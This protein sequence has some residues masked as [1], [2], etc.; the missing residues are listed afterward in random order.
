MIK[1]IVLFLL[2]F[3]YCPVAVADF[4]DAVAACF[5]DPC[6]CGDS[7]STRWENWDGNRINKGKNNSVCP[8]WN[9]DGGRHDNTCL[10]KNPFPDA[11]IGYYENLC[12]E[13][14]P[15][16][17][18]SEP[19]IRVRGQQCNAFGC[20][21][22]SDTLSWDGECVTLVGGYVFPLHR[23]CARIAMP[24]DTERGFAQDPGYTYGKHLNFE[25]ATKDDDPI[26]TSDGETIILEAPKLCVYYDP[27]FFSFRDGDVRP[28][29]MDVDP[30]KQSY[31]KTTEVHP[32]AKVILFF[33][34]SSTESMPI[35]SLIT[36][37]A[38]MLDTGEEGETTFGSVLKDGFSFLGDILEWASNLIADFLEEMGQ[39]NRAVSSE[40]Y[41]CVNLPM[42]PFPP[43]YCESVAPFFQVAKTQ[44]ICHI[45]EDGLPVLSNERR[46]CVVSTLRNNYIRNSIRV[47]YENF[48]PLC[49]SGEDPMTTDKCVVIEGLDAFA[50]AEG[51]HSL[52]AR[53]DIIKPCSTAATG[54]LCVKTMIPHRCSVT[55]D[56]C[57]DGFRVVY[58]TEVGGVVSAQS[59][60]R[61][62]LKDCG[63]ISAG[64]TC[65]KIWGINTGEFVDKMMAFDPIQTIYS[66]APLT[67]SFT[68]V[69]KGNR[70]AYFDA[71]MVRTSGFNSTYEFTQDPNQFCVFEGDS[72][73]G[74]EPRASVP[75]P[76][77]YECGSNIVPGLSCTSTYFYPKFI[78]SYKST[79]RN[80][81]DP[82]DT[83]SDSTSAVIKPVTVYPPSG[84][85]DPTPANIIINLAGDEFESF[86]T[87]D[88]FK[89]KPFSGANSPN[90]AS[91]F[92]IYQDN[93][94]P[95]VGT[96]VNPKAVYISG[97]EY[98]NRKYHLGGKYVCLSSPNES[99]CPE[100]PKLCVLTKLLNKD[101][102]RC[103][104][105]ASKSAAY[106]GL[107]L[108]TPEQTSTCSL[109]DSMS[110]IGGGTVAIR[111]CANNRKCYEGTEEL[112][113]L[114]YALSDRI[115]PA[116]DQG[117][118]LSDSK[119]HD[120]SASSGTS[121]GSA[122]NYDIEV[123]GLRD[124]TAVERG[125]CATIP[126]GTCA[127][128]TDYSQDNGYAYWPSAAS[129]ETSN[130]TCKPGW[131]PV[132][133]LVRKCVPSSGTMSFDLE[134]LY[135]IITDTLG[136]TS[137]QYND[138]KCRSN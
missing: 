130:G 67:T 107:S 10:V 1:K 135:K 114:S 39:I 62:D 24:A 36:S 87:D 33:I 57:Q 23:M 66:T 126:Q 120:T 111:S 93:I 40:I 44:Y 81:I 35:S 15:D 48:I 9:K 14:T 61:D 122:V 28:D 51:L 11:W 121:G 75:K 134:P 60:Y 64:A 90:P 49:T 116:P 13:E 127:E 94:L 26:V 123:Q 21:T 80:S 138:I 53:K 132:N 77:V 113:T 97:L 20:W 110:K 117:L 72:V 6:N 129:G 63:D 104:I 58:G 17:T 88:T 16:S 12:G 106:G 34:D 128:K 25:G 76:L 56:G 101:T 86:V 22:T 46:K 7:D 65:Q 59:Y 91:L 105:F 29:V 115:D 98:I 41:G 96:T 42:G 70:T 119:Y 55:S 43:P 137:K 83:S 50:S 89:V 103:S 27:S 99:K 112:C 95:V 3:F 125:L 30:Y 8:P 78:V 37:L 69:D 118:E 100:N 131:S 5:D 84:D 2:F 124:K 31:H 45:G 18:Y 102:V 38:D 4:W 136:A 79:Y 92:G 74:C 71:S 82:L 109:I 32:I 73:V 47:G 108:C 52:T 85:N 19:K 133:P 68:L 54:A